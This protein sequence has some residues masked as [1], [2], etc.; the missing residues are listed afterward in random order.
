M[1]RL[2]TALLLAPLPVRAFD[3]G[4]SHWRRPGAQREAIEGRRSDDSRS[5][6]EAPDP[7][8]SPERI[9]YRRDMN[10]AIDAHNRKDYAAA[11]AIYRRMQEQRYSPAV[12]AAITE[13]EG[14][15]LARDAEAALDRKDYAA[16]VSSW[17]AARVKW[18]GAFSDEGNRI[19][20]QW[21]KYVQDSSTIEERERR[22]MAAIEAARPEADRLL[23]ES[24]ELLLKKDYAK[25][26]ELSRK[27]IELLGRDERNKVN[28]SVML[29]A[30]A[31]ERMEA[32]ELGQAIQAL[33]DLLTW[34]A[35]NPE[36]QRAL[37]ALR[38]KRDEQRAVLAASAGAVK[39]RLEAAAKTERRVE[40]ASYTELAEAVE[41]ITDSP[42]AAEARRGFEAITR[43]DWTAAEALYKQ[44]LHKDPQNAE[45]RRSAELCEHTVDRA[46]RFDPKKDWAKITK[47]PAPLA[48]ALRAAQASFQPR[49]ASPLDVDAV[50]HEYA[51]ES[52]RR[53][54]VAMLVY[55]DREAAVAEML[56]AHALE[57]E[58][59][60]WLDVLKHWGYKPPP[61]DTRPAESDLEFLF[62]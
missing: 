30:L 49:Q 20:L 23:R 19:Y 29:N 56:S 18:P 45:L 33:E 47:A 6:Y 15:F 31:G 2:L 43:G 36:A 59:P 21:E 53:A 34:D 35:E 58:E 50:S 32:G 17:R 12:A 28:M 39:A 13:I 27:S 44:A 16:A 22:R 46:R 3:Y 41:S 24:A 5:S 4:S 1:R 52:A 11:L 25:A 40:G 37:T 60:V 62:Q 42:G 38:A 48:P 61:P 7:S 57:P 9:R 54:M 8:M 10:S 14:L 26:L 55:G 51:A